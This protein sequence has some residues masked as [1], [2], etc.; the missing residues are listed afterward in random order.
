MELDEM[1][2]VWAAHGAAME[3][4]ITINDRLL[5]EMLL[6][7]VRVALAPHILW[8]TLEVLLGIAAL[9]AVVPLL[10]AHRDEIRYLLVG[11]GLLV[12]I[13]GTTVLCLY[14]LVKGL[15]LNY[16]GEV[17]EIQ[18]DVEHIKLAEY[19]AYK[20]TVLGGVVVWLP[21]ALV[22]FEVLTGVDAL[23][24]ADGP[25]LIANL[26]FGLVTLG[27]GLALS[28]KYVERSDLG[29]RARRLVEALSGRGL[30]SATKHLE[31][32]SSFVVDEPA[33]Q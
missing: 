31:E 20:W 33:K 26:V 29:P 11:G 5:R 27:F 14:L 6:R 10:A 12:F 32:L 1:K 4:S 2:T 24:R 9:A 15:T 21:A 18:R 30:R 19:R 7:K 8:R 16:G 28:R 25:W 3:R 17:A 13:A 22:L 23:A